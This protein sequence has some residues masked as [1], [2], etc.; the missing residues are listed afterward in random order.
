[1]PRVQHDPAVSRSLRLRLELSDGR[2]VVFERR[3]HGDGDLAE[4]RERETACNTW[5]V[6]CGLADIIKCGPPPHGMV[7]YGMVDVCDGY[8]AADMVALLFSLQQ[9]I[10]STSHT[11]DLTYTVAGKH[12]VVAVVFSL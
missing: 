10:T 7:W 11:T 6:A 3:G 2:H 5:R 12:C 1:M 4:N 9:S 8:L